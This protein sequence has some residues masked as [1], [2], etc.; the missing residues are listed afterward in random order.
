MRKVAWS[1]TPTAAGDWADGTNSI[2]ASQTDSFGNTGSAS[3][4]FTLDTT[5]P[6]VAITSPG[7]PT[8]QAAQTITGTVDVADAGATVTLLDG[9]TALGS[10]VV[11]SNGSWSIPVTLSS[12]S[13]S[14]TAQVSDLAG[15][16]A[17]SSA[18]VYTLSTTAPTVSEALTI[19]T[20]SSASDHITSNDALSGSGL[21]N[22]VVHFTIDGTLSATTVT[23]NAQGAWSFTP[24]GLAD[25]AHTIVASQT[26]SFGNTGSASLSFTLDTT[27]PLVAIT[28][29]GGPTNQAAQTI[30]G[31]VDVADAGATVTLLDGTTALGSAVVQSNGSWSIPVTLSSGSNSLTAQVSDL[32]GNSA[33]SSAV[34]YTLSTTAPTVSEALTIDTGSSASDHITSNDALSGSGLA[35]TVVHFTIDGTLS[36]TT[37]TTNA[38]GAWSFTPTGL[39]DGAHTIVASQT[40][41]FGNT[42]SASLSFTLDTTAPLVAITSPG[43]PTNQAAQTITG[44]VDVADAGATV[45][46]LDGTTALGSAVV[47]SNGSWSIPVTLSSGSNSLTAQVSDLAGNSATSSA[48]VYTLSTTA[49]TVSEALT[50]DT[51][52]SASDHITSNDALSGSGLANT[53]VHFTIDGTLS[54]TTVTTNAQGAWSFTPTG[55]ADGAHTIVASQTDSFGNTGSASLSFTLDTTAPLV[56]ITSPGGP[57]NQAAQTITG[58][59]DVADAGATVTLLDGTTALGSAVVQSNGSWSIPVTLSS[60]SNSLT[61]QVSDLAGNSATSSAVVY[62]LSTTAPTVS[63]ALTI[64]TGSSASDHITSNDALS[65]SGLA[66]TVVHFTIDGTLSATTVT[67][68]AQGAWSFTPTGLADG[69]HTIVASQT[70][71]F[72]NTGSASLSFTLDTTAPL[73]AITSPGGPTNQAAQTIT[74]TVDV[75]DAGAT[76]TLLD[77]TTALGSAVVQSNGSWSIPV[78][79]SSGSNSLTA[80]VSDLA[81]NSATSSAVVYTLESA[82]PTIAMGVVGQNDVV[83]VTQTTAGVVISGTES[84]ADGQTVTI[85]ILNSGNQVVDTLTTVAS[86]GTWSTT[87]SESQLSALPSGIYT[88]QASVSAATPASQIVTV[89]RSLEWV[90]TS[91]GDWAQGSNWSTGVAPTAVDSATIDRTGSYSVTI[92]GADTVGS[93][94]VT[95]PGATVSINA[96]ANL[97][98]TG[99]LTLSAGSLNLSGTLSGGTIVSS[100]GTIVWS[101][102]TLSG[103]SYDGT[104]NLSSTSSYVYITNGLT[105]AGASGTGLGTIN[106]TGQST[107]IYAEGGQTINNA[108]LNIGNSNGYDYLYNYDPYGIAVLTLGA[109][110]TIN[111]VGTYAI[112]DTSY[113]GRS[114]SGIVNA[115]TINAGLSG[116]NFTIQG[117]GSFTNQGTINVSNGTLSL[118]SS[119]WSNSGT[120]AV[121]G[122]T[123]DLQG[124]G[125]TLAQ[126][127]TVTHSGGVVNLQTTLNDT[128]TTLN[129]GTG[130]GLGTLTLATSGT[131]ENGT[132]VDQGSRTRVRR[133]HA[134][135][136][137]L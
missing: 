100:G 51:G 53:V 69:A 74:G 120:I 2:M 104:L 86:A 57:T 83:N 109:S 10:A 112:L 65:G 20:G 110:L 78:T 81:G 87:L 45:T 116:G 101:G 137:E 124:N 37:V 58:T 103:V 30:T 21:A 111:Q 63:E 15:N 108:T 96:N 70:D 14:L 40:D 36:A 68:N 38:Q 92:S 9:T 28:S 90:A 24:T 117:S 60:G 102:G 26:D 122:G 72:G 128:G 4:S 125:L 105:L 119:S 127:G 97:A 98:V 134:V 44:T 16:S 17:T 5:A 62:T 106:L 71:S 42:G 118:T 29:P 33:T 131:I 130:T 3:L 85:T 49:P 61:A 73:V 6:L 133:R 52:S 23:T 22:T 25:G 64:D 43:G 113:Y 46:L 76:V 79:L 31:T 27:A 59:V 132:I 54:A 11:Q 47:Q 55:L 12:G 114:A 39:A 89:A 19:D 99:T 8:N 88:F 121:T 84:N 48:V 34:V 126:L 94:L 41:S 7:G 129:V 80:Q 75:A 35:N 123:L 93:L 77:G 107:Q 95:D 32:A 91:G 50:I 66:N 67:T 1:F 135:R 136:G 56:A 82:P 18:V 115:G 13:N